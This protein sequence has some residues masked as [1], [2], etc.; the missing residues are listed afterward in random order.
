MAA[1]ILNT[2]SQVLLSASQCSN[3]RIL[4]SRN[5]MLPP[6]RDRLERQG[7]L[8]VR[9]ED[10]G[11]KCSSESSYL[12]WYLSRTYILLFILRIH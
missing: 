6:V 2:D 3:R 5:L 10:R 11:M 12:S 1:R 7:R 4:G 9:S 8:R